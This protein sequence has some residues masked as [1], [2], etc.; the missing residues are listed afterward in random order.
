MEVIE[1]MK[2][3]LQKGLSVNDK[4]SDKMSVLH[5]AVQNNSGDANDSTALEEF[6]LAHKA[7]VFAK[8]SCGVMP[9]HCV[10]SK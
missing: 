10:F 1:I 3:L 9:I 8:S 4:N 5:I 2:L 6:L 7:D